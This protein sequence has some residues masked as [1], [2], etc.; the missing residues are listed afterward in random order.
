MSREYWE[1]NFHSGYDYL[2]MVFMIFGVILLFTLFTISIDF[3]FLPV[4]EMAMKCI[5]GARHFDDCSLRF[6]FF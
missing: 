3:S 6:E 4:L 5:L 1:S 2:N